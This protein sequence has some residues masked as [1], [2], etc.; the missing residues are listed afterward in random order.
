MSIDK[1]ILFS[2][3]RKKC[4]DPEALWLSELLIFHDCTNNPVIRGNDKLARRIPP[5]K[6]LF[7]APKGKGLPIGNL[8]SQFFAN[9]YLNALDQFVK[10]TLKCRYYLRYCDDFVLLA[11]NRTL[12]QEWEDVIKNF[13]T[14]ELALKLNSK[15]RKLQPVNNGVNFLGYIV[16]GD[17]LLVRKRVIGNLR[18]KLAA[19]DKILVSEKGEWRIYNFDQGELNNVFAT[20]TSYLGHFKHADSFKLVMAVW[21]RYSFLSRYF[22]LDLDNMKIQRKYVVPGNFRMVRQQYGYFQKMFAEDIVFFQV[23]RFFEF[24]HAASKQIAGLLNLYPLKKNCRDARYGFP[25]RYLIRYLRRALDNGKSVVVILEGKYLT[26]IKERKIWRRYEC[27]PVDNVHIDMRNKIFKGDIVEI[28]MRKGPSRKDKIIQIIDQSGESLSFAQP[29]SK[30]T[31]FLNSDC[32]P[33][34]LIRRQRV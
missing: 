7:H 11:D 3:V 33:N 13:L 30:V 26:K 19:Y 27:N 34:D 18:E 24:Y 14:T 32:L 22:K 15:A 8:N 6:T 17:Y 10:H 29:G 25:V 1:E 31:I 2:L 23:G 12:L 9:V 21:Q 4:P 20:F 16:R 28:L 5:H